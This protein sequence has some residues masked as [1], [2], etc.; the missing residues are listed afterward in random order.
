M[1]LTFSAIRFVPPPEAPLVA[2][3]RARMAGLWVRRRLSTRLED[4]Q[5][6]FWSMLLWIVRLADAAVAVHR[7]PF[8]RAA[9]ALMALA[10]LCLAL[11][12]HV[13][14]VALGA[15][16]GFMAGGAR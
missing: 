11:D 14:A 9:W 15:L 5:L 7:H 10:I 16:S 6:V 3:V 4:A 1:T 13:P 2:H 12:A 8:A